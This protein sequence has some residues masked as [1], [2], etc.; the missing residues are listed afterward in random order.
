MEQEFDRKNLIVMKLLHYFITERNYTP[1]VLQGAEDEIWL[2]NLNSDYK[3]VRIVSNHIL[4]NEQYKFDLFK[5]KHVMKKIKQKTF[6]LKMNALSIFTDLEDNVEVSINKNKNIDCISI[7]DEKDL[8]KYDF[9]YKYFPDIDN[10]LIFNE[11]G[12]QLFIKITNEINQKNKKGA[13]EAERVFKPKDG[14]VTKTLIIINV[15]MFLLINVLGILN[16]NNYAS[17]GPFIFGYSEYYR[18]LSAVFVHADI[19]HLLFNC[20]ALYIIG[21]QLEGFVGKLK[22]VVIYIGS[23]IMGSL[24]SAVLNKY[25]S[26]GASGAIFGLMGS[27]IYFGYHYR[28]YLGSVLKS[29]IIPLIIINLMIGFFSGGTIDNFGHI[30]G[31]VG[32]YLVTTAIGIRNKSTKLEMANA[33]IVVIVLIMFLFFL[34]VKKYI[35]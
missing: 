9:I 7:Y 2:E 28:V 31:L 18:L 19:F 20:Y 4:N 1:I 33:T 29:Q 8:K 13:E 11:N 25:A 30:G 34:G 12:I 16:M 15:M 35:G 21:T 26:V 3:I 27:L 6:S 23:A 22:Y 17:Y 14:L 32:G 24:L 5:A 10:K